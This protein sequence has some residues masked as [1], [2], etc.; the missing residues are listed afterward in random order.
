MSSKLPPGTS[1][2]DPPILLA[3]WFGVGLLPGAAGTWASAAAL[4]L[5]WFIHLGGGRPGLL[6][7]SAVVF[8]LGVWCASI[9]IAKSG[10]E[11]PGPVVIDEVLGQWLTL[12]AADR[13]VASYATALV[14][15]RIAD[16]WK[17][18][19]VSWADRRLK[20]GWG[21]MIDDAIA[22]AYAALGLLALQALARGLGVLP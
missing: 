3:T 17:P 6:A 9:Y 21:V 15:F 18:W 22:A 12:L 19:P 4:P 20:G 5:A 13:E 10:A 1:L 16:I 14:L 8:A 2:A 7:A 11:D